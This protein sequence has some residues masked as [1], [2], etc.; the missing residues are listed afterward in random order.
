[1][2]IL[3]EGRSRKFVRAVEQ[4]CYNGRFAREQGRVA[5]FV[6]ER[7]VF[8]VGAGGLEL[9]E[10]A[11]GIDIER[12]I[13]AHMDF[14]PTIAADLRT[15]DARLFAAEPMGLKRDIAALGSQ[16]RQ[17]RRRLGVKESPQ[18]VAGVAEPA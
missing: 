9:C 4:I 14:R 1:L 13:V 2:R 8:R 5:V 10:V 15:M 16:A 6:T 12:D 17:P 7:A 11:P 18:R 3:Q